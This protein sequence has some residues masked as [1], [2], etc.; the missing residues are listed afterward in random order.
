MECNYTVKTVNFSPH[1]NFGPIFTRSV[2]SLD[3]LRTKHKQDKVYELKAFS[4][5][6]C[7][8]HFFL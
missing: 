8:L 7:F 4:K 5:T 3:G 1:G 2:A 6:F